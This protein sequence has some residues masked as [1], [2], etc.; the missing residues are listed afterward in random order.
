MAVGS[1]TRGGLPDNGACWGDEQGGQGVVCP[2]QL[3]SGGSRLTEI[4]HPLRQG[5]ARE[6]SLPGR[7]L[8]GLPLTDHRCGPGSGV[9]FELC[10]MCNKEAA[11]IFG[12]DFCTKHGIHVDFPSDRAVSGEGDIFGY[13]LPVPKE[14]KKPIETTPG[15]SSSTSLS[16]VPVSFPLKFLSNWPDEKNT[17]YSE[18]VNGV[19]HSG[20]NWYFS[21]IPR[22][23]KIPVGFTKYMGKK[24]VPWAIWQQFKHVDIP[25]KLQAQGYNHF[26]DIDCYNNVLYA[27]LEAIGFSAPPIIAVFN[28]DTLEFMDYDVLESM[29]VQKSK[30]SLFHGNAAWVAVDPSDGVLYVSGWD[31][32]YEIHRFKQ[33]IKGKQGNWQFTLQ[34]MNNPYGLKDNYGKSMYLD[35]V[36]G[37]V[38]TP[39]GHLILASDDGPRWCVN[40]PCTN[41]ANKSGIWT[42]S[43]KKGKLIDHLKVDYSPGFWE[44]EEIE[45]ITYW[46]MDSFPPLPFGGQVH[47]VILDQDLWGDDIIFKHYKTPLW[48]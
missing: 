47:L 11:K 8:A 20:S 28:A 15:Q 39:K 22:I 38:I 9:L 48:L 46:D 2:G 13:H 10:I 21:Q 19:T 23:W 45:G 5:K 25:K 12:A 7:G 35:A 40:P 37:G 42:F 32:T 36:Q 1:K 4:Q 34:N 24:T 3:V 27:P 26:G 30:N 14:E 16:A 6:V 29:K 18:A 33:T 31:T 17:F 44:Y 43:L 41:D